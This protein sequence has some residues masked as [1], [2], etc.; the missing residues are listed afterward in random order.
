[1]DRF[2][3]TFPLF[4]LEEGWMGRL[5]GWVGASSLPPLIKKPVASQFIDSTL[6]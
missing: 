1:M 5:G 3:Y 2:P 6:H 4:G